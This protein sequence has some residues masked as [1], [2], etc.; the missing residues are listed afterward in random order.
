MHAI[1][2]SHSN[3][4]SFLLTLEFRRSVLHISKYPKQEAMESFAFP[5]KIDGMENCWIFLA[6]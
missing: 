4:S 1:Y 5:D 6:T 2:S 3:L